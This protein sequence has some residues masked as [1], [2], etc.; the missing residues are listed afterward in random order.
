LSTSKTTRRSHRRTLPDWAAIQRASD[1]GRTLI[2]LWRDYATIAPQPYALSAFRKEYRRWQSSAPAEPAEEYVASERHW[3]SKAHP[4]PD[5]LILGNGAA[6]RIRGGHLEA[7]SLGVTTRFASGP[8]HRKP[9]A[10]IFAGWGGILSLAAVHFCIAHHITILA[11]GY[12][13]DLTTFVVPR[14]TS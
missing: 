10:I 1:V 6:L 8:H 13:G 3:R 5:F 14:P 7:Y 2:S 4:R 9:K 12:L 11:T